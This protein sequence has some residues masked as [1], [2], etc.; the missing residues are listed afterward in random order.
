[1]T[2][3][4]FL[5]CLLG[6][7]AGST[8][9]VVSAT[10]TQDNYTSTYA[11]QLAKRSEDAASLLA[12]IK[13]MLDHQ[14]LNSY[15]AACYSAQQDPN[16]LDM[17]AQHFGEVISEA[18][19]SDLYLYMAALEI[20][21]TSMLA[22]VRGDTGAF[23]GYSYTLAPELANASEIYEL[24]GRLSFSLDFVD[25]RSGDRLGSAITFAGSPSLLQFSLVEPQIIVSYLPDT[26]SGNGNGITET[27]HPAPDPTTADNIGTAIIELAM[28]M[29]TGNNVLPGVRMLDF[30]LE[31]TFSRVEGG[32]I[33]PSSDLNAFFV[34]PNARY[35]YTYFF[36]LV[37]DKIGQAEIVRS[38]NNDLS[39]Y[40]RSLGSSDSEDEWR[41]VQ[42]T[43][44]Y[45]LMKPKQSDFKVIQVERALDQSLGHGSSTLDAFNTALRSYPFRMSTTVFTAATSGAQTIAT[46]QRCTSI[47]DATKTVVACADPPP[48]QNWICT[49]L[50]LVMIVLVVTAWVFGIR[51]AKRLDPSYKPK[52][53][54]VP[55][56]RRGLGAEKEN[57]VFI[58]EPLVSSDN[59]TTSSA[60]RK[61]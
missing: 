14:E 56:S 13:G 54:K 53:R 41:L 23:L 22:M 25:S 38:E 51:N 37:N 36:A 2:V 21:P 5:L 4:L 26:G 47:R 42:S 11:A 7:L 15:G 9:D 43:I 32:I 33:L 8:L 39:S 20:L 55:R 35:F 30:L 44:E 31:S 49:V 6:A 48:P 18:S 16:A 58:S 1:M 29:C 57:S 19:S 45:N 34:G 27:L 40:R 10:L 3:L 52:V 12:L 46:L 24:L 17:Y 50:S 28:A 59:D 61:D 60:V